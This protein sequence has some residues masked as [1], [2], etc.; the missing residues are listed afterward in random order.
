MTDKIISFSDPV[1]TKKTVIP[2]E[3]VDSCFRRNDRQNNQLF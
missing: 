3:A 1:R 2:P